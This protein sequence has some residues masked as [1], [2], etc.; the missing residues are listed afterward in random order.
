VCN[1]ASFH[2]SYST[3]TSSSSKFVSVLLLV[4]VLLGVHFLMPM[5][6]AASPIS[7]GCHNHGQPKRTPTSHQC[8]AAGHSPSIVQA[9]QLTQSLPVS[10][11]SVVNECDRAHGL[12]FFTGPS[13]SSD[14]PPSITP[15]RI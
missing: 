14:S 9:Y 8:C 5:P 15:L 13:L 1:S 6:A 3:V 4:A 11:S 7:A 2:A 10:S 12:S